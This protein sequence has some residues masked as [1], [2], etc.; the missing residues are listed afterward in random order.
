MEKRQAKE[1]KKIDLKRKVVASEHNSTRAMNE[2]YYVCAW[3]NE[4]GRMNE[5]FLKRKRKE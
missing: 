1:K 4:I 3:T 5:I 2:L